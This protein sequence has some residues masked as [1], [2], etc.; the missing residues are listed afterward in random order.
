MAPV[1]RGR[2]VHQRL[3]VVHQ[4]DNDDSYQK[5]YQEGQAGGEINKRNFKLF[6]GKVSHAPNPVRQ[7]VL[8]GPGD[9][10]RK[11]DQQRGQRALYEEAP[12]TVEYYRSTQDITQPG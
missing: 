5:E 8:Q 12:Q 6:I 9:D 11:G 4:L 2:R 10:Y 3:E 7:N 1:P